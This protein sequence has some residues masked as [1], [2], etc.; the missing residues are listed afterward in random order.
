MLTDCLLYSGQFLLRNANVSASLGI[1][2]QNL[3]RELSVIRGIK[4]GGGASRELE[5]GDTRGYQNKDKKGL[6]GGVA[7]AVRPVKCGSCVAASIVGISIH[8]PG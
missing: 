1:S 7:R 3:F 2:F 5:I 6:W 4:M 8:A